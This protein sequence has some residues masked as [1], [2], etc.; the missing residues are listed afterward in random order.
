MNFPPTAL[1]IEAQG[2]SADIDARDTWGYTALQRHA[3]NN[4]AVG[5]QALVEAGADHL[6]PSGTELAGESARA[7]ARRL[8]S[9]AVL[10]VFQQY[11]IAR[12]LPLPEGE[13]LL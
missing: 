3:T 9:Y 6:A 8:R 13:P 5:A 10:K 11:E 4:L 12:G 7:L 2:P 1:L